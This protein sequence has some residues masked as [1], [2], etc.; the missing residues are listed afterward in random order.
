VVVVTQDEVQVDDPFGVV[1]AVF[2]ATSA[3]LVVVGYIAAG[4]VAAGV[5]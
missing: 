4:L 2:W 3:I 5:L 1:R